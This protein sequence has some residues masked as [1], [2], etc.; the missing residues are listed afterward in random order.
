MHNEGSVEVYDDFE[1]RESFTYI[2]SS[3]I[4]S[5]TDG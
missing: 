5:G 3:R 1:K 2:E 4:N